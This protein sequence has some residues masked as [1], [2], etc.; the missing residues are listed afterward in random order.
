MNEDGMA[1]S[2]AA[3]RFDDTG[4]DNV[5]MSVCERER[6][7]QTDREKANKLGCCGGAKNYKNITQKL[8]I[9]WIRH[10]QFK[11]FA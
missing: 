6:D 1:T 3:H 11:F 4:K 9:K 10:H 7:R 8:K 5:V 2:S